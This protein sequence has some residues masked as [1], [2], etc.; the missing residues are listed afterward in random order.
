MWRLALCPLMQMK[1][2]VHLTCLPKTSNVTKN[3]N[4]ETEPIV[5]R[6]LSIP[7]LQ[8]KNISKAGCSKVK[9]KLL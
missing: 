6:S 2:S 7:G 8:N 4:K 3:I 1:R 9:T 5:F